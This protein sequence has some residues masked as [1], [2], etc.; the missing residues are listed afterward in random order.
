M[1]WLNFVFLSRMHWLNFVPLSRRHW[2][3]FVLL[4]RIHWLNF[5]PLSWMHWFHFV[6]LSRMHW[7]NFVPLSRMQ[8]LNFVLLSRMHSLNFVPLSRMYWLNFVFLFR[9]HWLNFVLLSKAMKTYFLNGTVHVDHSTL[10]CSTVQLA[11]PWQYGI[12]DESCAQN[13]V[14]NK[15]ACPTCNL[16]MIRQEVKGSGVPNTAPPRDTSHTEAQGNDV[17]QTT[18][19]KL[20]MVV[21]PFEK[22]GNRV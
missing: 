17:I 15:V 20:R 5:V 2:L 12:T 1:H 21:C 11:S 22:N 14:C 13:Y 18:F 8:W 3:N 4:S 10:T 16:G 6:P 19:E 9:M 7:L